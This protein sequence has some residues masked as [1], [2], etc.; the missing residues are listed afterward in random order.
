[1]K[2]QIL[3]LAM[4][5]LAMIFASF[6][7]YG[8][9]YI[10]VPSAA[11]TT[12][13]LTPTALSAAC[14][15]TNALNPAPGVNYT[16]T[17]TSSAPT[18]DIRWFV[19]NNEELKTA[20][21][22]VNIITAGVI[23]DRGSSYID[24]S[25]GTGDYI[26]SL[27]AAPNNAY[28]VNPVSADGSGTSHSIDIS[29]K[30]FDGNQPHE[31]LLVAFV[32]DNAGCTNNLIVWRIIPK[33]TFT[34]DIFALGTGGTRIGVAGETAIGPCVSPIASATYASADNISGNG[35]ITVDYGE[36][37]VFFIVNAN[38]FVDSWMPEFDFT[39]SGNAT[40]LSSASWAYLAAATNITDATAWNTI[41]IGTGLSTA[42]VIAGGA[43]AAGVPVNAAGSRVVSAN[44]GEYI[45][46]RVRLDYGTASENTTARNL[47]LAVNGIMYDNTGTAGNVPTFYD[48]RALFE[49]LHHGTCLIDGFTN[50]WVIQTITP[51]PEIDEV[52]AVTPDEIKT[53]D[54]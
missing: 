50:D 48:N 4:F 20:T 14:S 2:K 17:V 29:W 39:Y 8:Q 33:N 12:T 5:S 22:T 36:N 40:D 21:P 42:P 38:N 3:F 28:N 16:Y 18:N 19:I 30:N 41:D 6:N 32:A 15:T 52:A 51:R 37:W 10:T 31:I 49:D 35:T 44:G 25:D 47:T 43:S 34:L 45:V 1:M 27:G 54:E 7:S 26:L 11:P 13:N 23:L 9:T 24:A 46:V 53:G